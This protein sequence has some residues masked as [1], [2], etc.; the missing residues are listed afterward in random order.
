M[1][2]NPPFTR[3]CEKS[4]LSIHPGSFAFRSWAGISGKYLWPGER[5]I[6]GQLGSG[7]RDPLQAVLLSSDRRL[8]DYRH[9][10]QDWT[11]QCVSILAPRE[12]PDS[13]PVSCQRASWAPLS[14]LTHGSLPRLQKC[15]L[16]KAT[17]FLQPYSS[18]PWIFD[19][20]QKSTAS[21]P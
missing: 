11:L 9:M 3:T 12:Y 14:H 17:S 20:N 8:L 21:L 4:H 18:C 2:P 7:S 16:S 5:F 10:V 1:I 13:L 15:S 6:N 19:S